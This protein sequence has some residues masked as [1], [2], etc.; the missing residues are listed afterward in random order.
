MPVIKSAKKRMKQSAVRQA[1]NKST[2]SMLKTYVKK[3]LVLVKEGKKDEIVKILPKAYSVIDTAAK[4]N[5]IHSKNAD[6]KKSRLA[7]ALAGLESK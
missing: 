6:R 1:R 4:K 2:K 5:I 7:R 3:V